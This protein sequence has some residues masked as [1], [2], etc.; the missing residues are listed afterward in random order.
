MPTMYCIAVLQ[1]VLHSTDESKTSNG[2][3]AS[4]NAFNILRIQAAAWP[5]NSVYLFYVFYRMTEIYTIMKYGT[6]EVPN[7]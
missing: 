7:S 4:S 1:Y 3:L 2:Y 5:I 6:N